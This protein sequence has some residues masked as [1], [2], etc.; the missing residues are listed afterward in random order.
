MAYNIQL[1]SSGTPLLFFLT[2]VSDHLTG[3][4]G[5]SPT[6]TLS[7]NGSTTFGSPAGAVSEMGSGW[8]KVAPNATDTNTLG[9][10]ALHASSSLSDACDMIVAQVVGYDPADGIRLGLTGL[11][12][13]VPGAANGLLIAGANAATTVNITGNL[14]G[15]VSGSVG[16]VTGA[17]GSVTGNVGGNVVGSVASVTA[18]VT[19]NTDQLAGQTVTAGAG[20]TFPTSVA[21]PTNITAGTITTATNVTTVNGLAA[22]VITATSIAADAI[23]AAKIATGAVDADALATDAVNEIADGIL[24]RNMAT[25]TDSGT[26]STTT[27]TPRQALR[28]LRNKVSIAAGTATVCKEDDVAT[29]WTAA[30]TTTAGNPISASDP[31]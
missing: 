15:N 20:V 26:D 31:T 3:L 22:N 2:A 16:S 27:R 29:S 13:A 5:A 6:V 11:S 7:K 19:A 28:A 24:D 8:Y 18:R 12:T 30:I 1:S 10:L 17:V 25:G 21:S 9:P 23:T 14:T 4:T